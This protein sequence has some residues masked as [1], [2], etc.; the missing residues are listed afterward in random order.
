MVFLLIGDLTA[1]Y[2]KIACQELVF[3]QGTV[4]EYILLHNEISGREWVYR[5]K[6]FLIYSEL[7]M[8]QDA[9]G[10]PHSQTGSFQSLVSIGVRSFYFVPS[11]FRTAN[12]T[13][14]I[15]LVVLPGQTEAGSIR[16]LPINHAFMRFPSPFCTTKRCL[17]NHP[18]LCVEIRTKL[19]KGQPDGEKGWGR[20]QQCHGERE[21]HVAMAPYGSQSPSWASLWQPSIFIRSSHMDTA[22][23][24]Q[25][26]KTN[27]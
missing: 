8:E 7:D 10:A 14:N 2:S 26:S 9:C 16:N 27:V 23:E 21:L 15:V 6:N 5:Q 1:C 19:V 11:G 24:N 18:S 4:K 13:R 17:H 25:G 12:T 22:N 3:M 20:P